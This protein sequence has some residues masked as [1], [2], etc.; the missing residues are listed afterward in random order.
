M[1]KILKELGLKF[2]IIQF[3]FGRKFY[4]GKF[5]LINTIQLRIAPFWSDYEI[6]S[7]QSK[8]LKTEFY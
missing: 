5:Y 7:C 2:Y 8:T 1:R 4:R 6:T 3:K